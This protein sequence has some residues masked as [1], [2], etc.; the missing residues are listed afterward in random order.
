MSPYTV[1]G[2]GRDIQSS[3]RVRSTRD[4]RLYTDVITNFNYK[5][6]ENIELKSLLGFNATDF[7]SFSQT[8]FGRQLTLPGLYTVENISRRHYRFRF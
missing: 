4:R 5:L 6:T 8:T 7:E 2:D 3:L 1:T